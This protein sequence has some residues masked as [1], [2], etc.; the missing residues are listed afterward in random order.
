MVPLEAAEPDDRAVKITPP[1]GM[2]LPLH[3]TAIGK[4]HLAFDPEEQVKSILPEQMNRYTSQTIVDRAMLLEQLHL[5]ARE[6]FAG[7][8][9]ETDAADL[10][11]GTIEALLDS[12]I[13]KPC[14]N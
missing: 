6:G 7:D 5:V 3:C 14:L 4:A 11:R 13:S 8:L 2:T 12:S 10:R 9:D 1:I